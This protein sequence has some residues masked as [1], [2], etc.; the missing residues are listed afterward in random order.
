M[1]AL[2]QDKPGRFFMS[3]QDLTCQARLGI[4]QDRA[5]IAASGLTHAK[6]NGHH[7][8]EGFGPASEEE[9]ACFAD[10]HPNLYRQ[11]GGRISLTFEGGWLATSPL[12][13]V[14]GYASGAEPDWGG[15]TSLPQ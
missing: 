10:A 6:R 5:P 15:L 11:H 7:Y 14:P 2:A 12:F 9:A 3:A 4:Q 13:A 8:V 1:A